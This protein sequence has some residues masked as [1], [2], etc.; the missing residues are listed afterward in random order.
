MRVEFK[1]VYKIGLKKIDDQH[2][3]LFDMF[4]KLDLAVSRNESKEVIDE[5]I[6]FLIKYCDVHFKTEEAYLKK[7]NYPL[8]E[9]HKAIH[10]KF[11]EE[12]NQMNVHYR[13]GSLTITNEV[14]SKLYKW[15]LT[16]IEQTDKRY[17]IYL[18]E[19]INKKSQ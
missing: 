6:D 5:V 11:I 13:N 1:E 3:E 17:G 8:Y 7:Y 12:V 2:K 19:K 16:H 14:Q 9:E 4:N 15:L 18:Q 10:D